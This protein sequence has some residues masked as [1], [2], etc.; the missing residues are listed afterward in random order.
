MLESI[1][2]GTQGKLKVVYVNAGGLEVFES[3]ELT[4]DSGVMSGVSAYTIVNGSE[5]FSGT[6]R[7]LGTAVG[8]LL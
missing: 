2:A 1:N 8:A 4:L 5:T 6:A 3:I 7:V